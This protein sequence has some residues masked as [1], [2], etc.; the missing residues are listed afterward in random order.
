MTRKFPLYLALTVVGAFGLTGCMEQS[1]PAGSAGA[2]SQPAPMKARIDTSDQSNESQ[3]M[4]DSEKTGDDPAQKSEA[5]WREELTEQQFAILR[6]SE[7]EPAFENAYW[8][9]KTPGVYRC[10][11]CGQAL[12]DSKTKFKSGTGW[13]SFYDVIEKGNV[14]IVADRSM[15]MVRQEVVCSRC[16]GHLGHVFEDAPDQP[17]GLRYCMNSAALK[18][19][20]KNESEPQNEP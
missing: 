7:T 13:P 10:A 4:S 6:Q 9:E 1:A 17:T 12:F 19:D 14:D 5:Q 8:D 2:A 16:G 15:G 20:P 11:G 18:L 3:A